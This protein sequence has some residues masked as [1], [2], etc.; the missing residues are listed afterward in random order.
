MYSTTSLQAQVPPEVNLPTRA[1]V[2]S[3]S[4]FLLGAEEHLH[5]KGFQGQ[6]SHQYVTNRNPMASYFVP[7]PYLNA[8]AN[9][10]LEDFLGVEKPKLYHSQPHSSPSPNGHLQA[11]AVICPLCCYCLCR[12]GI[13]RWTQGEREKGEKGEWERERSRRGRGRAKR[14]PKTWLGSNAESISGV[15]RST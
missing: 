13:G 4:K 7:L 6:S 14:L 1:E 10:A 8:K 3:K 9:Y 12:W 5:I 2:G 15:Q 11:T